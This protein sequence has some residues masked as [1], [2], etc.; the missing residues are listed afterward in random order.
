MKKKIINGILLV[1]LIIA[2]SSAFVSCKDNDSDVQT[3]LLGKIANLQS[4]IDALKGTAGIKGD[5]G[6]KGDPGD[7]GDKGDPGDKGDKGDKGDPGDVTDLSAQIADLQAQI[8]ALKGQTWATQADIDAAVAKIQEQIDALKEKIDAIFKT[9]VTSLNIDA[10]KNPVF[11]FLSAPID[12]QSNILIACYGKAIE[13]IYFPVGATEPIAYADDLLTLDGNAGKLYV[14]VNPSS[15]DFSGKTLTLEGTSGKQA[16]VELSPL[17]PSTEELLFGWTRAENAFYETTATIPADK[18]ND[19][20]I[21]ITKQDLLDLK[22]DVKYLL[23]ERI[24]T[25]RGSVNLMKDLYDIY[26]RNMYS[27]YRLKAT[28]GDGYN[29]FS[30]TKIAALALKPLSYSFD[31]EGAI[32]AKELEDIEDQINDAFEITGSSIEARINNFWDKFNAVVLDKVLAN[33]NYALQPCLLIQEGTKMS[34]ANNHSY[35]G[36]ILLVPTSRSAEVFAPAYK[37]YLKVT[38]DGE[39]LLEE[40][41]DGTTLAVPFTLESGKKYEIEYQAVDYTGVVRVK[42]YT[43]Y[44]K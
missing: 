6:D 17:A 33:I 27:A 1:A 22:D 29:T 11:G 4:Q 7:K 9:Q 42:N 36:E 39:K 40:V 12:V 8:D 38:S 37:K 23:N 19:L 10:V 15:V 35:T 32:S 30:E 26:T 31:P 28:W 2:A 21:D 5:K 16:P 41:Y 24:H 44:G 20:A 18:L 3:E 34:R 14:T 43:I 25:K 13:D